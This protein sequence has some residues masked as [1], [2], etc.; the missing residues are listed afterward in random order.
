MRV[1]S[2]LLRVAI[3]VVALITPA[4]LVA[5]AAPAAADPNNPCDVAPSLPFCDSALGPLRDVTDN[6]RS[7]QPALVQPVPISDYCPDEPTC[8]TGDPEDSPSPPGAGYCGTE[9][10]HQPTTGPQIPASDEV[11]GLPTAI[12]ATPPPGKN[13]PYAGS[14]YCRLRYIAADFSPLCNGCRRILL[15]FSAIPSGTYTITSPASDGHWAARFTTSSS[16]SAVTPFN[17]HSPNAKNLCADKFFN[18]AAGADCTAAIAQFDQ[19]AHALEGDSTIFHHYPLEGRYFNGPSYLAGDGIAM[20]YHWINGAYFDVDLAG[21]TS[22]PVWY[23]AGYR[24]L[25]DL[26]PDTDQSYGCLCEVPFDTLALPGVPGAGHTT[27]SPS[28]VVQGAST[29]GGSSPSPPASPHPGSLGSSSG[30]PNTGTAPLVP[31]LALALATTL[32]L[33]VAG[34]SLSHRARVRR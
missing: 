25:G 10:V 21:A 19:G 4:L 20:P 14:H 16:L 33:L 8:V 23:N 7:Y 5:G 24:G 28:L 30:T 1:S 2:N 13:F 15:D 17:A 12:I 31:Y 26:P 3:V 34:L 29:P 27:W 11:T 22:L 32:L 18:S 6:W 9:T